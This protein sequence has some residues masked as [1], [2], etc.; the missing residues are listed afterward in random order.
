MEGSWTLVLDDIWIHRHCR[1]PLDV[2]C[3]LWSCTV[4]TYQVHRA[5]SR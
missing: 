5:I 1:A 4:F 3:Y 2:M